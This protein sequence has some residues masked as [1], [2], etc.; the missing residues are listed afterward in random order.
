MRRLPAIIF[1]IIVFISISFGLEAQTKGGYLL[2]GRVIDSYDEPLP[3]AAVYV[4][5]HIKDGTVTDNNGYFSLELP[6]EKKVIIE[7]SFIGMKPFSMEYTG[8]KEILI[9]MEDDVNMMES[10]IVMGKQNTTK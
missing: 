10:A 2:S 9:V 4:R 7:A 8:Q 3:S 1:Y 6:Q 5:G